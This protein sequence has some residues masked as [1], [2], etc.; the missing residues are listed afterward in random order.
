MLTTKI[1]CQTAEELKIP[2]EHVK[3]RDEKVTSR[4]Q[5]ILQSFA[6]S[7][8]WSY[9]PPPL[10]LLN[11]EA[12][13]SVE[14][15][16]ITRIAN[17]CTAVIVGRGAYFVLRNHPSCLNIFLHADVSFSQNRVQDLYHVSGQEALQIKY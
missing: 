2:E 10:N 13:Y 8:S 5:T 3:S 1:V 4:W 7:T 9:A 16:I 11:D 17:Q 6:T 14:S 15:E 12:L